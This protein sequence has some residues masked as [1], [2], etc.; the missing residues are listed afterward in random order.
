MLLSRMLKHSNEDHPNSY[1]YIY[2]IH[3]RAFLAGCLRDKR[4]DGEFW[5]DHHITWI[6]NI[7]AAKVIPARG[8][9]KR[10]CNYSHVALHNEL[11]PQYIKKNLLSRKSSKFT[12]G[13]IHFKRQIVQT[14]RNS[15]WWK[16]IDIII[17]PLPRILGLIKRI[18]VANF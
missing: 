2:N 13:K 9:L 4:F 12:W 8:S 11:H 15:V 17:Y 7:K 5:I 14:S 18:I 16:F 10:V 6:S 3:H 1:V